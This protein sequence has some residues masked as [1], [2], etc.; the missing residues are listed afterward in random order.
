VAHSVSRRKFFGLFGGVAAASV[1]PKPA[2]AIAEPVAEI[3][4]T[5]LPIMAV[6][7]ITTGSGY[8]SLPTV[9]ITN[10]NPILRY[11]KVKASDAAYC[12]YPGRPVYWKDRENNFISL[13]K[14]DHHGGER[15]LAGRLSGDLVRMARDPEWRCV[16]MIPA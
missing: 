1:L 11:V 4:T 7:M 10:T 3:V 8:S 12:Y 15:E 9:T 14:S 6:S 5:P 16:W 13:G 2:L